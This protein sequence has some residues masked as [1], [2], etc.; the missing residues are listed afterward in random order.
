MSLPSLIC[1][2]RPQL[3]TILMTVA[4]MITKFNCYQHTLF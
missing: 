1:H 4:D 3:A 2:Y